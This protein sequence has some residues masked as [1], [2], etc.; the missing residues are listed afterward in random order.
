LTGE[1]LRVAIF[2]GELALDL[3]RSLPGRGAWVHRDLGCLGKAER[4]RAFAK[5]LRKRGELDTGFLRAQLEA[6]VH[7]TTGT[8]S[9]R[10]GHEER[11]QVDPS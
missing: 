10:A 3:R 9:S 11:K 8:G 6:L 5:A 2:D 7:R 4:K 1:L